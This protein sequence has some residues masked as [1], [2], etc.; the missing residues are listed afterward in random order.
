MTGRL[1]GARI[2]GVGT[3]AHRANGWRVLR[4]LVAGLALTCVGG[5]GVST[6]APQAS[7]VVPGTALVAGRSYEQWVVAQWRWFLSRPNEKSS[8]GGC[9]TSSQHGPV[10]FL[11]EAGPTP[12]TCAI[13]A[14]RYIMP[15]DVPDI[16]CSTI[17]R[18]PFH[19]TTNAGLRRCAKA[20]WDRHTGG[21]NVILD[22]TALHPAGYVGGTLAFSF[23]QP[24]RHNQL[25]VPGRTGGRAAVYGG[26]T[27]LRPL[28]PGT[29]TL[30]LQFRYAHTSINQQHTY[31]LSVG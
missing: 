24:P 18:S 14:G 16:D 23:K 10:W 25:H 4:A 6:A 13:P 12:V 3:G 30:V 9:I 5:I 1:S 22:G 7:P 29:H 27:I 11:L 2:E 21:L 20:W 17:E 28:S 26:A 31:Y 19:A 15:V 8:S